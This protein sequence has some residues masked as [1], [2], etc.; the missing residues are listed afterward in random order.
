MKSQTHP[1]RWRPNTNIV[2]N[3]GEKHEKLNRHR[4]RKRL[5]IRNG[6]AKKGKIPPMQSQNSSATAGKGKGN[7][8]ATAE[9]L[10]NNFQFRVAS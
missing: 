3:G 6:G 2:R 9:K 7:L 10:I 4:G 5:S 8:S 1:Q